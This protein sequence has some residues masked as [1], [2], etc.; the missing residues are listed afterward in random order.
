[1]SKDIADESPAPHGSKHM[2]HP[3]CRPGVPYPRGATLTPEGVNFA[4]F[5]E[6]GTGVE[7][8]LFDHPDDSRESARI[9]LHEHTD[10]IWH[11]FVPGLKA[12][13]LYGLRVHGPYEPEKGHRFNPAK[14]LLDP[15]ARAIA[16][17]FQWGP[18]LFGYPLGQGE[19]ADLERSD[20][21]SAPHM[22]R[23]VIVDPAFDWAGDHSPRTPLDATI[24]Y[25]VH[26]KGFT[27]LCPDVPEKLRGTYAGLGSDAAIAYFKKLGVTAVELLPVHQF[28]NDNFLIERG[29]CN[30]WGYNSIGFFAPHAAYSSDSRPGAQVREF[31][32]MVMA[33]HA[34]GL[35]VILDVVYNH[36]AEG[37]HLG[38]TLCFRGLDNATYYHLVSGSERHC[39]DYTGC[40]NSVNVHSP[41]ALQMIAD[42]LRYWVEEMHVDGFRFDL[43]TTLGRGAQGFDR[44]TGFFDILLQDPV[45][46][47][48]KLIAEP[49]D[50]GDY[51]YQVGGFPPGWSE[52]NGR[53]RDCVR[54]YWRGDD[55]M[56]GEFAA[57]FSGSADIYQ[58]GG[59]RPTA[60]VN[61]VV[62]HDGF[63]LNDLV[64]YD[65]KHNEANGEENRDGDS[66]NRSWNCGAEGPTDVAE[67]NTLRRR[68]RR[69]FLVT[70]FLSQ[71]VPMLCGGDE[72][73][74][75]QNG[76]NNTYCH[77]NLLNW[78]PW[79]AVAGDQILSEFTTRLIAFRREHP[80]FR[81]PK[82][83]QG[84]KGRGHEF[85][86][87]HWVNPGGT[88]MHADEWH[89]G[90]GRCLG[91]IL[92]GE[93]GD[94]HD[95]A[96]KPVHDDTFMVLF[97][98][99]HEPMDFKLA[100]SAGLTWQLFLDTRE[101]SGFLKEPR[102]YASGDVIEVL[103]RSVCVLRLE[104]RREPL[105]PVRTRRRTT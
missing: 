99:H 64:S 73:G 13:Q 53:Y 26:V 23:C 8:C 66:H 83:F 91:A 37:S 60:S 67:I 62:A 104:S 65:E 89:S 44:A 45:L 68:Q 42:S 10:G 16:G 19:N 49:W 28:V 33:L 30:Y 14:L 2:A 17:D 11:G 24:F 4:V 100:G 9:V 98:A 52:W 63:T 75:T 87:L 96:G 72:F 5:S 77:D 84:R 59:R 81:R 80:I 88:S 71:G 90:F 103:E 7:I 105:K 18:E 74:R 58:H 93:A 25:E 70:L 51:G 61:F 43:A 12:G 40:G 32:G 38:P 22:P 39:M 50:I 56:I 69:N 31:K 6:H 79:N 27:K 21:D 1:M 48:V 3:R 85:R 15:Y 54:A 35:E 55:G 97:N 47:R 57:R 29:L 76:N 95:A 36:T 41:R 78:F 94:V 102:S 34:A 46:S 92:N 20:A 82:F 101:E 86:D